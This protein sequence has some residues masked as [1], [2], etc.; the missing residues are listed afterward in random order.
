MRGL[1][2]DDRKTWEIE[3]IF[4]YFEIRKREKT[5]YEGGIW[6]NKGPV[7]PIDRVDLDLISQICLGI[8]DQVSIPPRRWE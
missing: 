3:Y 8:R 1:N 4:D 6:R 7:L 5:G 2:S